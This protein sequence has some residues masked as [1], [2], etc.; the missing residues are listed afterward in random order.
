MQPTEFLESELS[1]IGVTDAN[2]YHNLFEYS[3]IAAQS[4]DFAASAA[5]RLDAEG[6]RLLRMA[7]GMM[8]FR[9]DKLIELSLFGPVEN[10][11]KFS[12]SPKKLPLQAAYIFSGAAIAAMDGEN[13]DP[14][15]DG[16]DKALSPDGNPKTIEGH[17][18]NG[19][20][21]LIK[22]ERFIISVEP[23]VLACTV[24]DEEAMATE[25][26][27][28]A[29]HTIL[30]LLV[31]ALQ[32]LKDK[33]LEK[34][35]LYVCL[36]CGHQEAFPPSEEYECPLCGSKRGSLCRTPVRPGKESS[37]RYARLVA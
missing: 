13:A 25:N 24:T 37:D 23:G 5:G 14:L 6:A 26:L 34:P 2:R 17:L 20:A 29:A 19:L 15:L 10:G 31:N 32:I 12:V 35:G 18:L 9:A 33:V 3:S 1:E 7:H 16:I 28:V 36:N 11:K 8:R 4:L 30:D 22:S 27:Q 21:M